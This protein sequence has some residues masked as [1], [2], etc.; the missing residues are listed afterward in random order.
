[1]NAAELV[2][3]MKEHTD[4]ACTASGKLA[5]ARWDYER[6]KHTIRKRFNDEKAGGMKITEEAIRSESEVAAA[7]LNQAVE[8]WQ[9]ELEQAKLNIDWCKCALQVIQM[10]ENK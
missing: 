10:G 4:R 3:Q 8:H 9:S 5:E 6:T 1:M 7:S 2:Q